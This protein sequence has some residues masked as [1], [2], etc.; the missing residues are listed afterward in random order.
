[1]TKR[2]QELILQFGPEPEDLVGFVKNL[3]DDYIV[4]ESPLRRG[5]KVLKDFRPV[6]SELRRLVQAW[7]DSGPNIRKLLEGD[8]I[9]AREAASFRAQLFPTE[10]GIAKL[11]Y[12][13]VP[14]KM[15]PGEPLA[16]AL[17]HFLE[18]LINP[19]NERLGG[20]CAYCGKYFVRNSLGKKTVYCPGLCGS[21]FASRLINQQRRD[22]DHTEQLKLAQRWSLKWE[23]AKT[24]MPWKEWVAN[25]SHIKKHWLTLAVKNK[26]LVEPVKRG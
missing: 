4:Y 19:D 12:L 21:R 14:E 2:K 11:T 13:T 15:S 26:E 16:T 24:I 17:G 1:V 8:P 7:F 6:K 3:N 18:F 25:R 23:S 22:R 20:P 5:Q 9:L 10:S